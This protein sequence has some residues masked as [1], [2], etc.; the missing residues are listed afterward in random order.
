V[1]GLV[2]LAATHLYIGNLARSVELQAEGRR[3]AER[4]GD[5]VSARWLEIQ[6]G[7]E[8]YWAGRPSEALE[9]L[10]RF[11][12]EVEAGRPHYLEPPA[13]V[14][15]GRI[16]LAREQLVEALDDAESALESASRTRDIQVLYPALAFRARALLTAG[17]RS[18]AVPSVDE[19]LARLDPADV[20]P[21]F[22]A[23]PDLASVLF[24]LGRGNELVEWAANVDS[25][26]W[27]EAAKAHAGGELLRAA[28]LYAEIG[29]APEQ[30]FALRR[31]M[32]ATS[33]SSSARE[34]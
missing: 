19:L 27:L 8:L 34:H 29:A 1:T 12:A 33:A 28:E 21:G 20:L 18:R 6:R 11:I 25:S 10:D 24:D 17:Q 13:R 31:A 2:N 4:F 5:A 3:A 32:E 15:R 14:L 30:A 26:R 22:L 23:W 7:G 16:R 9:L